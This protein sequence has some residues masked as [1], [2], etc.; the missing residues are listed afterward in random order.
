MRSFWASHDK[1][2]SRLHNSRPALIHPK[3]QLGDWVTEILPN[4]FNGLSTR[5]SMIGAGLKAPRKPLK[6][7]PKNQTLPGP[8]A[9][10]WGE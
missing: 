7:F 9:E 4:R 8:Q 10:A 3:L 6:R 5:A 1:L 2:K